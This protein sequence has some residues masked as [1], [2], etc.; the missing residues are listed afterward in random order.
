MTAPF[1]RFGAILWAG[2]LV[3][4]SSFAAEGPTP[5]PPST[6]DRYLLIV[7][8]SSPMRSREKAVRESI[9]ALLDSSMQ[10]ELRN[11]DELGLWTFNDELHTGEF[12]LETWNE[13]TRQETI[14]RI[15]KFVA[16]QRFRKATDFSTVMPHLL[17]VVAD[18]RR[19][20]ILLFSDGDEALS[21]TP[22]D[23]AISEDFRSNAGLARE[24]RVPLITV[25]R[26]DSG[27]FIGHSCALPPWSIK[28]PEFPSETEPAPAPVEAVSQAA[29]GTNEPAARLKLPSTVL[30][31][32]QGPVIY[33]EPLVVT[34]PRRVPQPAT[35]SEPSLEGAVEAATPDTTRTN[36]SPVAE[37]PEVEGL[38]TSGKPRL[39]GSDPLAVAPVPAEAGRSAP[40]PWTRMK[41]V[42]AAVLVAG[43]IVGGLLLLWRRPRK[44]PS[45]ITKSMSGKHRRE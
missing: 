12:A 29:R 36:V 38:D 30:T 23:A 11:G 6:P 16:R 13:S 8:V 44:Q 34:G 2:L 35:D 22:F 28:F 24:Q 37:A 21:G 43:G 33:T 26:G 42:G 41:F 39:S 1:S 7:D 3:V 25:L 45:L 5:A 10:G 9:E 14:E 31:T 20:T 19:I 4:V 18:S 32:N 17:E 15:L 40:G 27:R